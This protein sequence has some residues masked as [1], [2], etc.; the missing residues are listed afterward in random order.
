MPDNVVD[1]LTDPA[2]VD[3]VRRTE[4]SDSATAEPFDRLCAMA[5]RVLDAPLALV[6]LVEPDRQFLPGAAGL[7]EPVATERETPLSHSICQHALVSAEPLRIEDTTLDPRLV[8]NLAIRDLR[9]RSYLGVPLVD[10]G[11]NVLGSFCVMD[12]VTRR[13]TEAETD[14][15]EKL[16][17]SVMSEI[18]LL[19]MIRSRESLNTALEKLSYIEALRRTEA[20]SMFA[21]TQALATSSGFDSVAAAVARFAGAAVG[22]DFS[23]LAVTR[24]GESLDV[25]HGA[26][27]SDAIAKRWMTVPLD[28]E[29]PLGAAALD[30]T[31]VLIEDPATMKERFPSGAADAAAAGFAALVALPLPRRGG[32]LGF[33][34]RSAQS[35]EDAALHSLETVAELCDQ[36]LDRAAVAD[37]NRQIARVLQRVLLPQRLLQIPGADLAARYEAAV[38]DIDVGGDWYDGRPLP[39]G[40]FVLAMGDVVGQ[41]LDAAVTMA[42]LRHAFAG[43]AAGSSELPAL[44]EGIDLVASEL[45]GAMLTTAVVAAYDVDASELNIVTAGHLPVMIR[46]TDGRVDMVPTGDLPL[47]LVPSEA[48]AVHTVS[49]DAGDIVVFYT[50]GLVERRG[51][52]IDESLDNLAHVLSE[53]DRPESAAWLCN[54]LLAALPRG[55]GSDDVAVMVLIPR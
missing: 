46:R 36:A 5:C 9:A 42:Q 37:R 4:L 55:N 32:A 20:E 52:N 29:T 2:R 6:S 33:A 38:D 19:E 43:L 25:W 12:H 13:W 22:A 45:E 41:G 24:D 15:L 39:D 23:N 34:W 3:A 11:G 30:G 16:S 49:L 17:A 18:E 21:L 54:H 7:P 31:R 50:D 27:L 53:I 8:D 14:L 44:I 28:R 1:P 47:G 48:R 35:F 26:D 51:E 10:A 40:R